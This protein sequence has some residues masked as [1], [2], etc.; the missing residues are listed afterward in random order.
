MMRISIL[1]ATHPQG[2]AASPASATHW[3][4]I[5]LLVG[6]A[7][8]VIAPG[9]LKVLIVLF[10]VVA[11]GWIYGILA[12]SHTATKLWVPVAVVFLLIGLFF[13]IRRGLRHLGD[14]EFHTRLHNIRGLHRWF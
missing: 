4:G 11:L 3:F 8:G 9:W 7:A 10:D 2:A 6:M 5:G 14:T 1:A 13:G 12:Y